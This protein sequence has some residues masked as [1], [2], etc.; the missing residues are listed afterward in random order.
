MQIA[1]LGLGNLMRTDDALGMLLLEKV[2]SDRRMHGDVQLIAGGTLGLDLLNDLRGVTHLLALDAVDVGAEPGTHVRFAGADLAL[3]PISQSVHLL[4][5]SEL[6]EVLRLIDAAPAQVV[7]LGAQPKE[8][9]WGT[10][11]TW[12]LAEQLDHLVNLVFEQI[13]IWDEQATVRSGL[14][15]QYSESPLAAQSQS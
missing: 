15:E 4:G 13:S 14:D 11:L 1:V 8:T 5:F 7:L 12:P 10:S 3:M 6:L 2:R 9:G